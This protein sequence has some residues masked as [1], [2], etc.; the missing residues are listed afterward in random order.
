MLALLIIGRPVIQSASAPD[1][2]Q[3]RLKRQRI[4]AALDPPSKMRLSSS[5][6]GI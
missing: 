3:Q 5:G 4:A 6:P 2:G 1:F